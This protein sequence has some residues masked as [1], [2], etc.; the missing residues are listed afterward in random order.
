MGKLYDTIEEILEEDGKG[1]T[2]SVI[3]GDWKSVVGE[4]SYKNIVGSHGLADGITEV[5]FSLIFVKEM[6]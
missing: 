4:E 5:K 1:D 3:L 2:N 6:G